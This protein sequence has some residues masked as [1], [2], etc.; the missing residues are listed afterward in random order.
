MAIS[1]TGTPFDA[2][3]DGAGRVHSYSFDNKL[4]L[5][6]TSLSATFSDVISFT[7]LSLGDGSVIVPPTTIDTGDLD[8]QNGYDDSIVNVSSDGA[9][10]YVFIV[11]H[12]VNGFIDGDGGFSPYTEERLAL[13][14]NAGGAVTDTVAN[15]LP[16]VLWENSSS[17]TLENGNIALL[18]RSTGTQTVSLEI[19]G[20]DGARL[21][22]TVLEGTFGTFENEGIFYQLTAGL[23]VVET[24]GQILTLHRDSLTD[25]VF[26]QFFSQAGVSQGDEFQISSGQHGNESGAAVFHDGYLEAVTLTD[27]RVAITW[28]DEVDGDINVW[29]TVL[30][31]DGSVSVAERQVN[32][33]D[34]AAGEQFHANVHALADGG[35]AVTWNQ[36]FAGAQDPGGFVQCFAANGSPVGDTL[37]VANGTAS[38]V[39]YGFIDLDG[40]GL[41][42]DWYGNVS[43]LT[44]G[45]VDEVVIPGQTL[46]G[47]DTNDTLAGGAGD[48]TILGN[49]G[50]D[51]LSGGD[52]NDI[53]GGGAGAD[54]IQGNDG[55]DSIDGG[56]GDDLIA[57]GDGDD[58][59]DG[60]AGNDNIGG[61][62]GNDT[63]GGDDGRD[64]I[65]AGQGDDFADGGADDDVMAGG[66]GND[67]LF[68]GAGNDVMGA[69][70]GSDS[71]SGGIGNDNMGGGFGQ[72]TIVAGA[73]DD[74][75]GGG[76]GN[77]SISGGSGNDF[78][79]GGGRDDTI[80]GGVGADTINGGAGNDLLTGGADADFFVFNTLT[81]GEADVITDFEAGIDSVRLNVV[82]GTKFAD[83]MFNAATIDGADG[84][85][86]SVEGQTMFFADLT[87]DDVAKDDF[88]LI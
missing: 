78:L 73:G 66:A 34:F 24:G 58:V 56:G 16:F 50:K 10:G 63:I 69:S 49:G 44:G 15:P 27:G 17:V 23:D 18:S 11:S 25:E 57:G 80:E 32:T 46:T 76:E 77:D 74:S 64:T 79:A 87:L 43:D 33:G 81:A 48:D 72:D 5:T 20:P 65:G 12:S 26:G 38:G 53:V 30:N 40:S 7:A 35:F 88:V 75:V 21:S 82:S 59:I 1:L 9:G 8:A 19:M 47:D 41:L 51:V 85:M 6:W 52:G 29:V 62:L 86:L 14:V 28:A 31:A 84:V 42:V 61:G 55:N 3:P 70:Y 45:T 36:N 13:S 54:G 39:G 4:V 2:I 60:G 22:N 83:L 71:L 37:V 68:G 67:S